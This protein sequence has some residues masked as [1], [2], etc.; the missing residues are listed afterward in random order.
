MHEYEIRQRL[1]MGSTI[2]GCLL[3]A[4]VAWFLL[5]SIHWQWMFDESVMH[6]INLLRDH[7]KAPYRDI[8]DINMPGAYLVDGWAIRIFGRGDLG[9]RFYEYLLLGLMSAAMLVIARPYGWFAGWFGAAMF[10]LAHA[11]DGPQMATERDEIMTVLA[12]VGIA[13]SFEALRRRKPW[14]MVPFGFAMGMACTLKPTAAPLGLVVLAM[15]GYALH[16]RREAP[17]AYVGL[18]ALG[19]VLAGAVIVEFFWSTHSFAAFVG[20]MRNLVPYYTTLAKA[21]DRH[22]L[23]Y[24]LPMRI[25]PLGVALG[26]LVLLRRDWSDWERWV[27]ALGV[28]FGASSYMVQHKGTAYHRYALLAFG[29]LWLGVECVAAARRQGWGR[30]LA[31]VCVLGATFAVA[32][33]EVHDVRT[34][35]EQRIELPD[36]LVGDLTRLGGKSLDGQVQCLDMVAGCVTALYRL[37]L[38]ESQLF[39]GDCIFFPPGDEPGAPYYSKLFWDEIHRNPP[40]VI[41]ITTEMLTGGGRMGRWDKLQ[42]WPAFADYLDQAYR[43][44]TSRKFGRADYDTA[45][46]IYVRR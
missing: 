17:A 37:D 12:L 45:Y 9:W 40:R 19:L 6:Y 7:G 44:D 30:W 21:S 28:L 42:K 5:Y 4:A 26:G 35:E 46:R 33:A 41:V 1:R 24:L 13:F 36:A 3:L 14:L 16:R 23:F 20:L 32:P 29:L 34:L 25:L 10:I 38:V 43:L 2:C 18:G 31:V 22:L 39:L 15:A 27:L 11:T 8:L